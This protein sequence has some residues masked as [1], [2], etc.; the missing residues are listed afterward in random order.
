MNIK[1]PGNYEETLQYCIDHFIEIANHAIQTRDAFHV[2]L[3]GG[4]TPKALFQ[5]LASPPFA[6]EIDW[7]KV[8]IYWSD[9]RCVPKDHPDSNYKMAMD[10]GL[11]SLNIQKEHIFRMEGELDP[12]EAAE[13]YQKILP[14]RFDLIMLG[15]GDDGHTASLFPNTKALDEKTHLV[16]ANEV[17]QKE[18][19][20]LTLT[21]PCLD[22]A[23]QIV[24]Y[25]LG[26]AKAEIFKKVSTT[27]Q[28]Y[29]VGKVKNPL[30]I[31]DSEAAK[32]L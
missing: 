4:S 22:K 11:S 19:W 9:E 6:K 31:C 24:I 1:I 30:F 26:S 29:P 20:R 7:S 15:M 21:Y 25:V 10:A 16:A 5:K 12:Q 2:A 28:A 13:R 32:M 17:P 3:S 18:T 8:R 14:E 27:P 23:R